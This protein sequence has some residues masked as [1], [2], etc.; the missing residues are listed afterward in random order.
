MH[1]SLRGLNR[2][3]MADDREILRG[4]WEGKIPVSFQLCSDEVHTLNVPEPFYL[5]VPRL[6]Y[7]P[8]VT[9]KV[10]ITIICVGGWLI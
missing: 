1:S 10:S 2:R 7:F 9:D 8:L 4:I 6:L 3:R 5:M